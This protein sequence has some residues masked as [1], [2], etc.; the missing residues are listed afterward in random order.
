MYMVDYDVQQL[1]M[2]LHGF[3]AALAAIGALGAHGVFNRDFTE[4]VYSKTGLSGS[5]G[6]A[7]ALVS[8]FG[9]GGP[10]FNAFCGLL[11]DALPLAFQPNGVE[12][13]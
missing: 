9:A 1:E 11:C 13:A 6:W 3:D 7:A 2:Q 8:G 5:L 12:R 10:A 4:L